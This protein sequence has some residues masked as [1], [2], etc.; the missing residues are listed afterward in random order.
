M[1]G[2]YQ[3]DYLVRLPL[4]LAQLYARAYNGKDARSRHQNTFYLFEATI[5]LSACTLVAAYGDELK[6]GGPRSSNF[7][8]RVARL[9]LPSLGDWRDLVR[10]GARHFSERPASKSH[11]LTHLWNQ[12][13][14]PRRDQA[15]L[16]ELYRRIKNGPD[17]KPGGDKSCSLL[18]VFDAIVP[19]RNL[20]IGHGADR[21]DAF[22]DRDMGP[23]LF[24]AA[25]ELLAE[26]TFDLLGP[27][28]TRLVYAHQVRL[29]DDQRFEIDLWDLV[30]LEGERAADV[31]L[32]D[33]ASSSEVRPAQ[34]SVLWPG[35]KLPLTVDP[36]LVYRDV[37]DRRELRFLNG[38]R[39]GKHVEYLSYTSGMIDRDASTVA[40]LFELLRTVSGDSQE[41]KQTGPRD[42]ARPAEFEILGRLGSGST[43]KVYLARQLSLGRLV[44]LKTLSPELSSDATAVARFRREIETLA[45]CDDSHIVKILSHG[46]LPD[47]KPYYAME[48]VPGVGLDRVL[49]KLLSDAETKPVAGWRSP[50]WSQAVSEAMLEQ[51]Q[52]LS[53]GR[54]FDESAALATPAAAGPAAAEEPY[55]RC[56]ARVVRDAARALQVVHEQ[57]LIH[58]DVRPGNLMITPD[59]ARVVLMDFGLAKRQSQSLT[60]SWT[61]G[62][63]RVSRYA[64]AEQI[65]GG[66]VQVGPAADVRGLGAT[67]W[68]LCTRR[69]L[70]ADARDDR[71][72]AAWVLH[73]DVPRLREIDPSLDADLE[74][75]VARATERSAE[76]RLQ[77]ARELA[78]YLDL[79]LADK[80][81]PIRPPSAR[82]AVSR[83]IRQH[84]PLVATA[85]TA[86]LAVI[87]VTVVAFVLIVRSRNAAVKLADDNARLAKAEKI[88]RD[89]AVNK[90][91]EAEHA[92]DETR[93]QLQ[94]S[95][96][97]RLAAESQLARREHGVQ[98]VLL[99]VEALQINLQAGDT[100][101]TVVQ[102]VYDSLAAVGGQSIRAP[103]DSTACVAVSP[104]CRW[105]A[106]CRK[107]SEL[108]LQDLTAADKAAFEL[109]G[110]EGKAVVI[111]FSADGRWLASAGGD[112]ELRLWALAGISSA[113]TPKVL[114]GHG[115]DLT[116]LAFSPNGEWLASAD[117]TG[118]VRLWPTSAG[119]PASRLLPGPRGKV[120]TIAFSHDG[121]QLAAGGGE[122]SVFVWRIAGGDGQPAV[123]RG[124]EGSIE[125]LAFSPDGRRLASGSFDRTLRLWDL[126][127]D[128][129]GDSA[130]TLRAHSAAVCAAAFSSD[131][132][133]LASGDLDG[134]ICVWNMA[135]VADEDPVTLNGHRAAVTQ[136]VFSS[137]AEWLVSGGRDRRACVWEV[138]NPNA[139]APTS[140]RGHE[141]EIAGLAISSDRKAI[142]TVSADGA[143]RRWQGD[144][145]DIT[146]DCRALPGHTDAVWS[147][148][149]SR[150]GYWLATASR[151]PVVRLWN[152]ETDDPAAAP[153]ALKGH[154]DHVRALAFSTDGQWL[155][156]GS[157]DKTARLWRVTDKDPSATSIVLEGHN[158]EVSQIAFS[159][160]GSKLVTAGW[161]KT[162]RVW[163]LST[164]KPSILHTLPHPSAVIAV[165]FER[166]GTRLATAGD[167]NRVRLWDLSKPTSAPVTLACPAGGVAALSF[168]RDDKELVMAGPAG[169]CSWN[170]DSANATAAPADWL[171]AEAGASI[172]AALSADGR[173]LA[174]ATGNS[175]WRWNLETS[176]PRGIQSPLGVKLGEAAASLSA[177]ERDSLVLAKGRLLELVSPYPVH[178][179][180]HDE[181]ASLAI[182]AD[183]R[184]LAAGGRD[185][186]ARLWP[187]KT[188]ELLAA[189]HRTAGR[190]LIGEERRT[191]GLER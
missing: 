143:A 150:D 159:G 135:E 44:A 148:A 175:V 188:D 128:D 66:K 162:A 72:L 94:I 91:V 88:A 87:A 126:G 62:Q 9:S 34:V 145:R 187:L 55:L 96:A 65:A 178:L 136:L 3:R 173:W 40:A 131:A 181:S 83:W 16:V 177:V 56:V 47:G 32:V 166:Q 160:D 107:P 22:Y 144:G 134:A 183:G 46:K 26:G 69:R 112:R 189:A 120:R 41:R 164:A 165:A 79:Y 104:D 43:G 68:E 167:D 124:H 152:L 28:G 36:L 80:P 42:E 51:Q 114:Q 84:R 57:G 13:T 90:R 185:G 48:Y 52:Q 147:L 93:R 141:R 18:Q 19:Y 109:P 45:R 38:D 119:R 49:E 17:G 129:P 77:T 190:E 140:L 101:P 156:T 153:V 60:Q 2:S 59:G 81:L 15:A 89:E 111:A 158:D 70:F 121:Q 61:N 108:T 110:H 170:L 86:L 7:D 138:G 31:V 75:I 168:T 180:S 67:C 12:L 179:T 102:A 191:F 29:R 186:V 155:A 78:D 157:W 5:K 4:P 142:V 73:R 39:N 54:T 71:Q 35:F 106:A 99:A 27:P 130:L 176:D 25:N 132:R 100:L 10:E 137:D 105:L 115:G 50:L 30:G 103:D 74:A 113:A 151:E 53:S 122:E 92:R 169:V 182:S 33:A 64:A 8:A 20:V 85:M 172:V 95:N 171:R 174:A 146:D 24:P 11:P 118:E 14:E 76:A 161:D 184:W 125:C 37:G 23:L 98:A 21:G 163:D 133:W 154:N 123:L 97:L 116:A 117:A 1:P 82:E 139:A 6:H 127:E 149:F 58:R 63:E